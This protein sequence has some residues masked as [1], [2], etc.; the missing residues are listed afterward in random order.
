MEEKNKHLE[1][2]DFMVKS[3]L[4]VSSAAFLILTPFTINNIFHD[5]LLLALFTL[6]ITLLCAVNAWF[7]FRGKYHAKLN[8]LGMAPVITV[9][10]M[11][12][13]NELGMAGSYW[14]LL[15]A[16][17]F[18][19]ILPENQAKIAN[20][21]FIILVCPIAWIT[22]DPAIAWRFFAVLFGVSFST[23][24][25]ISEIYKQHYK[26]K[27]LAITDSLTGL[28]NRSQLKSILEQSIHQSSRSKTAMTLIML[29]LDHFKR[30]N[31]ELGHDAGD[32]VLRTIGSFL[33]QQFRESDTVFRIGG[34]E[35]LVL[36]H[37]ADLSG[38]MMV[39]E[40]LR[41]DMET[42]SLGV[43]HN[44]TASI[45]V[46]YLQPEMGWKEWMKECDENM[47]RAKFRGRNQV[48]G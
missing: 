15:G 27:E 4:G 44:I 16:L 3:T 31:D 6:A 37:N 7:G 33:N 23:Y 21:I 22:L 35:F 39:A 24:I 45:G 42:L 47:Y 38:G 10:V 20:I 36:L 17:S 26:L 41:V 8:L 43:E 19:L 5:R 18:Y 48:V 40:K 30:I 9:G 14:G 12:A 2:P 11:A 28:H 1:L 34:E 32:L 25:S 13:I 46:S 29:D